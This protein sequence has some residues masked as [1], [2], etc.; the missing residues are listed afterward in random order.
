[1]TTPTATTPT[2][3]A[4]ISATPVLAKPA[5]SSL[6]KLPVLKR[7]LVKRHALACSQTFRRGKFTRVGQD[8]IDEVQ[9]EFDSL[10]R[11]FVLPLTDDTPPPPAPAGLLSRE[12]RAKVIES[13]ELLAARLIERKVRRHPAMGKTLLAIRG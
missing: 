11:Q 7:A 12:A 8:F 6:S 2:A 10:L 5:R 1:M 4:P 9:G 13:A 3:P